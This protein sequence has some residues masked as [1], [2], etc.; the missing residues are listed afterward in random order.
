MTPTRVNRSYCNVWVKSM[1]CHE[2]GKTHK[3][4]IAHDLDKFNEMRV[5]CSCCNASVKSMY[6]HERDCKN[7]I[8]ILCVT[9]FLTHPMILIKGISMSEI[10]NILKNF[11]ISTITIP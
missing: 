11:T 10:C 4:N 8:V 5:V 7:I 9:I 1:H 3:H 6:S 2:R